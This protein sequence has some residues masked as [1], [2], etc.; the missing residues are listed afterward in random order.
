M[1]AESLYTYF[2]HGIEEREI[3]YLPQIKGDSSLLKH[4]KSDAPIEKR[5]FNLSQIPTSDDLSHLM[6]RKTR[7]SITIRHVPRTCNVT[8]FRTS[9]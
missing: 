9:R 1:V 3:D 5:V 7:I 2:M 4:V 8:I 6:K